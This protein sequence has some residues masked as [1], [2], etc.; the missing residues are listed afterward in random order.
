M[1]R[2]WLEVWVKAIWKCDNER[3]GIDPRMRV[4]MSRPMIAFGENVVY[5][6]S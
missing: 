5:A 4:G 1:R 2:W 6:I 3:A